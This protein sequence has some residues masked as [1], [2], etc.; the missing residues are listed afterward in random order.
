MKSN[1]NEILNKND[2]YSSKNLIAVTEQC[3]NVISDG[4]DMRRDISAF[5]HLLHHAA[6]SRNV[7]VFL[8][9]LGAG[10]IFEFQCTYPNDII[11][12]ECQS[13]WEF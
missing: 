6:S 9:T 4:R 12:G 11:S 10:T 3:K 5:M 1:D 8:F 13:W 7:C 2:K